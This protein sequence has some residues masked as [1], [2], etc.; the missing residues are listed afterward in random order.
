MP[1]ISS[2]RARRLLR[3][4]A[5][6]LAA[7]VL[8][9]EERHPLRPAGAD[10]V[11]RDAA[12]GPLQ[13]QRPRQ[14]HHA[15]LGGAVGGAVGHPPLR[16]QRDDVDDAARALR[17]HR[18]GGGAAG[19]VDARQV[20]VQ[21]PPPLLRRDLRERLGEG[22]VVGVHQD[23]QPSQLRDGA[24]HQR[25]HVRLG[26]GVD[27]LGE[28]LAVEGPDLVGAGVGRHLLALGAGRR[29]DGDVGAG[30]G[31]GDGDGAADGPGGADDEGRLA[32]EGELLSGTHVTPPLPAAPRGR[33]RWARGRRPGRRPRAPGSRRSC[34]RRG[35]RRGR[36]RAGPAPR[37]GPGGPWGRTCRRATTRTIAGLSWGKRPGA[38]R[39]A[40][41]LRPA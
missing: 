27:R 15:G 38:I 21:H 41:M 1:A 17:E 13:R 26:G 24:L 37:R 4:V 18:R 2:G 20:H 14:V 16:Q 8:V 19:Q 22:Q 33:S 23:V 28:P 31:E 6:Q 34:S 12:A 7:G 39:F 36:R 40:W 30:L 25:L 32:A 9:G 5:L 29:G 3:Q 10:G 35:R 11:Y